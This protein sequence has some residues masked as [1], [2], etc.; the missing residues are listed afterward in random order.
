[1]AYD[2]LLHRR[3]TAAAWTS[4][5]PILGAGEIGFET[6]TR[7]F[8]FG[9]GATAWNSLAYSGETGSD[10]AAQILAKLVT[11]DGSGSGLDADTVRATTPTATGL[12]ILAGA[13]AAAVRSILGLGSVA[14]LSSI[15][16][17]DVTGLQTA[18]DGK[19]ATGHT[20]AASDI[21]SGTIASARLGSGTAN[22]TTFL[23]G[24]GTWAA[25]AG[26]GGGDLLAANNLSDL[27]NKATARTNLGLFVR[28]AQGDA[29][30]TIASTTRIIVTNTSFT[31]PRTWT[32]PAASSVPAGEEIIVA[33]AFGTV[34]ATNTL[35]IARAGA[36]TINATTSVVIRS[37][38]GWRRFVSNGANTWS[39][40]Q[41]VLRASNN[42]SDLTDTAAARTNLGLAIGTNVQAYNANLAAI[43]GL[44]PANDDFL[45]RKAGAWTNRT[46]AQVKTDLGLTGTNSGDQT[47]TL[48]GDVTGSGTGSFAATISSG[49]VT[50]A[51]MANLAANSIIGNNTGSSATP[52]ALTGTQVTALLDSFAGSA[53]GLVPASAG[54]T[55]NFLRADGT[56]AAPSGGGGS[57]G[58]SDT[59]V[60]FNDGG[61]FG[62]DSGFVFN[63]TTKLLTMSGQSVTGSA[64]TRLI[65]LS[66][67][68][69]TSGNPALIFA[70]VTL[71]AAGST[72]R[73]IDLQQ[74]GTS[75]FNVDKNGNTMVYASLSVLN[76]FVNTA[77]LWISNVQQSIVAEATNVFGLRNSTN[78]QEARIYGSY[79]SSTNYQRMTIKTVREVS[80]TLS[81]ATFTS[82]NTIPA[83][84]VL[85]GVTTRV[86]TAITG[87]TTYSVGDGTDVD[88]WG[89]SIAVAANSQSQSSNFTA[90][91]ATGA[92]TAARNVVL[93]A[94]GSNFTG[95]V[96]EICFHYLTTEA[97]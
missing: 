77:A 76:S 41:G 53:K 65:D 4:A 80:S 50:L 44:S 43:A 24:D 90:A 69:N 86:N 66:S 84:A 8:K 31:A 72:A 23:R 10:T 93:T 30:H 5:N 13:S 94:N 32:L 7:R 34:S 38:F 63:K 46:V 25:P 35:T 62:G 2:Q 71:T 87:A 19:A 70:N 39:Y 81:G 95:G 74:N 57:P 18:L 22:S 56:W 12:S 27:S 17:A 40:D 45:Q 48:T 97:D 91:G 49:V 9:N 58:G 73:F 20:H 21:T 67:T 36:D 61:F 3:G 42:L 82:V 68:W 37:A 64:A 54:G 11:V 60:Q 89:A 26:G 6:D 16:I 47:I 51:K 85:I 92:A 88:L 55:S 79:V 83:Y 29:D 33:D 14:L 78:A 52:L 96:V 28:V 1:M 15:A 75:I 59:Q